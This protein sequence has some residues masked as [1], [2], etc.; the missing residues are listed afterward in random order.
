M[1]QRCGLKHRRRSGLGF[2]E[3]HLP[4]GLWV[5][6]WIRAKKSSMAWSLAFYPF[7]KIARVLR[8]HDKEVWEEN[9]EVVFRMNSLNVLT[10]RSCVH[11]RA[12]GVKRALQLIDGLDFFRGFAMRRCPQRDR[13]VAAHSC[14]SRSPCGR[15]EE[16]EKT[17]FDKWRYTHP[18]AFFLRGEGEHLAASLQYRGL[19]ASRTVKILECDFYR[20]AALEMI[21]G[22]MLVG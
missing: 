15:G 3:V 10:S 8:A 19:R 1:R 9:W 20:L 11:D 2:F 17:S 5:G 22:R 16:R 4:A 7:L 21:A 6:I 13:N 12:K 18:L 14:L